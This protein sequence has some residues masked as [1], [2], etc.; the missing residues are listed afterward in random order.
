MLNNLSRD[1]NKWAKRYIYRCGLEYGLSSI[2][3]S[4]SYVQRKVLNGHFSNNYQR[5]TPKAPIKK[6]SRNIGKTYLS[7]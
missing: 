3:M 5:K 7:S 4:F 2:R 6:N 1:G